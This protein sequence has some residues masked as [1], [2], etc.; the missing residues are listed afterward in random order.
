MP[1]A[2]TD[3]FVALAKEDDWLRERARAL[4]EEHE[5]DV[6]TGL[7][8]FLELA[9]LAQDYDLDLDRTA[10]HVLELANTDADEQTIF[11]AYDYIEQGLDVMDAFHAAAARGQ[12]VVSSDGVY[13]DVGL[14]RI[15]LEDEG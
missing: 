11:Q 8:T 7:P 10:A 6:R 13:E 1:Y 14:E 4:L 5:G 12:A 2:D 15:P 3:F 9:Y